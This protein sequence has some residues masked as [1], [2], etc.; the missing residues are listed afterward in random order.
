M[1][2]ANA[3][4]NKRSVDS[5]TPPDS[6]ILDEEVSMNDFEREEIGARSDDS[7]SLDFFPP[8]YRIGRTKFIVVTG[9]VMS[10]V[11]KG[12]CTASL[13]HLLQQLGFSVTTMKIDGYL[14]VDAG[15]LNPYRHGET[16]VLDDGT[17]CD[18]D[19]G[20]YER[21]LDTTLNRHNYMTSGKIYARILAKERRGEY[22]GRDVQ[23]VPHVTGEIKYLMRQ[24]A[25]EGPYDMVLVE[26]GGTVG[27]IENVHFI[28]AARELIRDEGRDN[29]MYIHVT[30]VPWSE[31]TGE[32]K[33][34]PT[35]HSIKK[36][37]E[38]GVQPD[39]IV[40]RSKH[41]LQRKVREKISLHCNVQI[42]HVISS[43][44]TESVYTLPALF[45]EQQF[46]ETVISR[47]RLN[48]P[49]PAEGEKQVP[50]VPFVRHV[51]R[52]NPPL[53]IAMTG[54][55]STM[56]DSYL[57]ITNALEHTEPAEG[58]HVD[59]RFLDTTD[60][61]NASPAMLRENLHD[62]HGILV[63]GGYGVRG[64]EGMIRCIR[65]ARERQVPYL[66]LCLGFQLAAIEFARSVCGV[67]K[68]A[69]T[70]FDPHT[71]EPLICL[72][73]EQQQ[74]RDLGGT[75][76]LGGHDVALLPGSRVQAMYGCDTVR[77]RFRH[78]YELKQ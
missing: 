6:P 55:Y 16:F 32:Q 21:F 8:H 7:E 28:E 43:P 61:D 9:G 33:S 69:S 4:C 31:A 66:G 65:Y 78:R 52:Q 44:D 5:L 12:V 22:L 68:A 71:Q 58:V 62:V 20:T 40:C 35:Q 74:V 17:E 29:V 27:D 53:T 54:K 2:L 63:P 3:S 60:F 26:I 11:G 34:K 30:M 56:K 41:D 50:F 45:Q 14:N 37:L 57:S 1:E 73:P 13:S 47:L 70:E 46:A 36:L 42:D 48:M 10:G 67:E 51:R 19:L 39:I 24:K 38:M 18:L 76:R 77:E 59:V 15:T 64:T 75:Q 49:Y 23:I 25:Q 72:L